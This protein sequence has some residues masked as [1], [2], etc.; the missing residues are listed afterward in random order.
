[1]YANIEYIDIMTHGNETTIGITRRNTR[2]YR[3][4]GTRIRIE[5]IDKIVK[6]AINSAEFSISVRLFHAG[7]A[8]I[9]LTRSL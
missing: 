9:Y 3:N 7:R 4:N 5:R 2:T 6:L 1:M 8:N